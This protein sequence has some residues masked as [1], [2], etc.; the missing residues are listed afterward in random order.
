[1][2]T[3]I[4]Y[5]KYDSNKEKLGTTKAHTLEEAIEI[6]ANRKKLDIEEFKKLFDIERKR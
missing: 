2:K 3:Y 1:M 6:F 5:S 4:F